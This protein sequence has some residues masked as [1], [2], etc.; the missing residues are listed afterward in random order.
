MK[1]LSGRQQ[2]HQ[3]Q[4]QRGDAPGAAGIQEPDAGLWL[5]SSSPSA[6]SRWRW[7]TCTCQEAATG[8][9]CTGTAPTCSKCGISLLVVISHRRAAVLKLAVNLLP[10]SAA[11]HLRRCLRCPPPRTALRHAP[12]LKISPTL[13]CITY[14]SLLCPLRKKIVS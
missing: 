4:Q 11:A 5:C 6:S 14:A 1:R 2:Q 9:R 13:P 8:T 7:P 3:Q 10:H 12:R